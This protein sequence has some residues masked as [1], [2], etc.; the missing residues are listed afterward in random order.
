M[1]QELVTAR[2]HGGGGQHIEQHTSTIG[3]WRYGRR[4]G[5]LVCQRVS[6]LP[7]NTGLTTESSALAK[8]LRTAFSRSSLSNGSMSVERDGLCGC[9]YAMGGD[10]E[11]TEDDGVTIGARR[12]VDGGVCTR[13]TDMYTARSCGRRWAGLVAVADGDGDALSAV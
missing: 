1:S 13:R 10:A 4:R 8:N 2:V 3:R 5:P 7:A 11:V 12:V 6:R 9:A